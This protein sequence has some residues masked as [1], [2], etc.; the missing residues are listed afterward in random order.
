MLLCVVAVAGIGVSGTVLW[1][2]LNARHQIN[3]ACAGL[4]PAGRVLALSPAGGTISHRVADEGTIELDAGLPQDCEIFSTEAGENQGSSSGERWFF[5]G[6]VG[7]LPSPDPYVPEEPVEFLITPYS[8]HTYPVEPL[9]GGMA[10]MVTASSVTVQLP[11][12]AVTS[13]GEPVKALWARASLMDPGPAF[14]E[15]GQMTSHDRNVLAETA[16]ITANNFAEHLGC[17]DRLPEP[18][19]NIPALKEGPTAATRADGTCGWYRESGFTHQEDLPDQVLESRTDDKVWDEECAL[20]FSKARASDVWQSQVDH[21]KDVDSVEQPS[22]P[23]EWW[24]AYHTY[25]GEAAKNVNLPTDY[26]GL[27]FVAEQG[28]AGR[29][30]KAAWWAS[31]VCDGKPQVH[32]MS[33][34]YGYNKLMPPALEKMFHAYVTDV[35]ERRGCTDAKFPSHSTFRAD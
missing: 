3:E 12:T 2:N 15:N 10:G 34:A 7:V 28:K 5:T 32:T 25:S 16:V 19:R 30:D 22:R 26:D 6:A 9:G 24:V 29:S 13:Y 23:G 33:V 35:V 1:Q 14:T 8:H 20:V 4:V 21:G 31:S 11:C 17:D 27:P 18:P